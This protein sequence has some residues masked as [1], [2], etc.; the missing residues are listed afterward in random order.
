MDLKESIEFYLEKCSPVLHST[1]SIMLAS[2]HKR[3]YNGGNSDFVLDSDTIKLVSF[4]VVRDVEDPLLL[5][6][7]TVLQRYT[8]MISITESVPK[9]DYV[10]A[11]F[12]YKIVLDPN[13]NW[14]CDEVLNVYW[15][16]RTEYIQ[17]CITGSRR[18]RDL[19][20]NVYTVGWILNSF[21]EDWLVVFHTGPAWGAEMDDYSKVS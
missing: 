6:T 21:F 5:C 9:L 18:V 2:K 17:V 15:K 10:V 14:S 1:A 3:Q 16:K 4:A 20:D 13:F 19:A 8:E 11:P 7:E 12:G